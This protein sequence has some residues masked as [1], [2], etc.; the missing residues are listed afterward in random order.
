[1]IKPFLTIQERCRECSGRGYFS[2]AIVGSD[3]FVSSDCHK[4]KGKGT[5][6]AEIYD[7]RDFEKCD[8]NCHTKHNKNRLGK[9]YNFNKNVDFDCPDCKGTGYIIPKEYEPYEIKEVSEIRKALNEDVN[10]S[11][12]LYGLFCC[13]VDEHNLK[14]SDKLAVCRKFCTM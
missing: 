7:L 3:D 2:T 5:Q 1:M 11:G 13:K 14:D 9:H 4:C 12:D 10:I 8:C 6:T